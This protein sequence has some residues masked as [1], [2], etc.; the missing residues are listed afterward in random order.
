MSLT[1][2]SPTHNTHTLTHPPPPPPPPTHTPEMSSEQVVVGLPPVFPS[3]QTDMES[4]QE[5]IETLSKEIV[6]AN[7]DRAKAAEYGLVLLEEKQALACQNDEL[8]SLFDAT[9]RELETAVEVSRDIICNVDLHNT[10]M[11]SLDSFS[12]LDSVSCRLNCVAQSCSF[13]CVCVCLC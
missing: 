2:H 4:L 13:V 1:T 3:H 12:S 9:K 7:E 5:Q 10:C 11:S 6:E 8:N